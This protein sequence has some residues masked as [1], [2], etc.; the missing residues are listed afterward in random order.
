MA[1]KT[2]KPK[3]RGRVG[4]PR[5][6]GADRVYSNLRDRILS[7]DLKPGSEMEGSQFA[8]EYKV[9]RT[10]IREAFLRLAA[11][12][13]VQLLPNRGARVSILELSEI[14][15]LLEIL[16]VFGRVT[17]RWAAARTTK[18]DLREI[19][20]HRQEW[21]D[22]ANRRDFARMSEVNNRFHDAIAVAAGN[23]YITNI[24][25]SFLSSYQRL[26]CTIFSHLSENDQEYENYYP[27][28]DS[29]HGDMLDAIA[30]GDTVGADMMAQ[31]HARQ[32]REQIAN[33]LGCKTATDFP[34]DDPVDALIQTEGTVKG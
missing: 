32:I 16:E 19:E 22:V 9:S 7:L 31:R 1:E 8:N 25:R 33:V 28:I 30:A 10:L 34:I 3:K 18:A 21:R 5:G 17:T 27:I 29:E 15:E 14:P 23:Q 2:K 13:L 4:R 12:G 11:D 26:S 24:Y 20:S 6:S